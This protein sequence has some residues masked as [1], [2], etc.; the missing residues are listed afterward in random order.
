MRRFVVWLHRWIGLT[1]A[2]FLVTVSLTGTV[3]AFREELDHWLNSDLFDV[4]VRN[5]A[6]FDVFDLRERAETLEPRARVDGVEFKRAPNSSFVITLSPKTDPA[7]NKP[8]ELPNNQLFF[9]PYT[10]QIIGARNL[11]ESS[12][13]RRGVSSA[14]SIAYIRLWRSPV[15]SQLGEV[16]FWASSRLFGRL[17]A[18]WAFTLPFHPNSAQFA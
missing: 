14:F 4:P 11:E 7:T 16:C 9:D 3:L 12:L 17:T 1:M 6:T 13:G 8:F 5:A 18:S 15:G 2:T 10:G